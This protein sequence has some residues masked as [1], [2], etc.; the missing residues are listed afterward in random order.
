MKLLAPHPSGGSHHRGYSGI[1][2]EKVIQNGQDNLGKEDIEALRAVPDHKESFEIGNVNDELQ[3]NIW[4]PDH[5]LP[6]FREYAIAHTLIFRE[7]REQ[8]TDH[9]L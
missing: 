2:V 7:R 4:V 3:P 1:G 5:E 9:L 6:G 8:L